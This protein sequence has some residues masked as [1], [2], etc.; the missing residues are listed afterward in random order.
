MISIYEYVSPGFLP[1][2]I[3]NHWSPIVWRLLMKKV[4]ILV[5]YMAVCQGHPSNSPTTVAGWV[6]QPGMV[7]DDP[8]STA[9]NVTITDDAVDAYHELFMTMSS[10]PPLL[11]IIN[12]WSCWY[13]ST[14]VTTVVHAI[15]GSFIASS[16]T[17]DFSPNTSLSTRHQGEVQRW[18]TE[19]E[20]RWS[21]ESTGRTSD[22]P[23]QS[24]LGWAAQAGSLLNWAGSLL[25]HPK[26]HQS[27]TFVGWCSPSCWEAPCS[28]MFFCIAGIVNLG[29]FMICWLAGWTFATMATMVYAS[30][31]KWGCSWKC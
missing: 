28:A 21:A 3:I 9:G 8:S 25:V 4:S 12:G 11:V 31:E 26:N 27:S 5:G 13:W 10:Y 6:T 19:S 24:G 17:P 14:T 7:G 29:E 1:T 23:G 15:N 30:T 20:E 18:S 22:V 16:L 2:P